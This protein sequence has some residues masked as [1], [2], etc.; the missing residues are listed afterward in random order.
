M[1]QAVKRYPVIDYRYAAGAMRGILAMKDSIDFLKG[2]DA[3]TDVDTVHPGTGLT[4]NQ[5]RILVA[6]AAKVIY[7]TARYGT[8]DEIERAVKFSMIAIDAEKHLLDIQQAKE[9]YGFDE[10]EEKYVK[11]VKAE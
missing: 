10:L 6:R 1:K 5:H 11:G 3:K 7:G 4:H 8:K 9:K 2:F